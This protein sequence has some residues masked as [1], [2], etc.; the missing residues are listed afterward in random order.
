MT[1]AYAQEL[2]E[3]VEALNATLYN[4]SAFAVGP[5]FEGIIG[6][7]T[8]VV[9]KK[10]SV[11]LRELKGVGRQNC[12]AL[13]HPPMRG[14]PAQLGMAQRN[15]V[16]KQIV[17]LLIAEVCTL[18]L[19]ISSEEETSSDLSRLIFYNNW[20]GIYSQVCIASVSPVPCCAAVAHLTLLRAVLLLSPCQCTY[21]NCQR[22]QHSHQH[23]PMLRCRCTHT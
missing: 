18:L 21:M 3:S 4:T 20:K 14:W 9:A 8:E 17:L 19:Q 13:A 23:R 22:V 7:A 11:Q 6:V 2:E 16:R 12:A 10:V 5:N 15:V 1:L